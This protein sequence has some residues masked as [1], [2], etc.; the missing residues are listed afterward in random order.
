MTSASTISSSASRGCKGKDAGFVLQALIAQVR[1]L[2][3]KSFIFF[4]SF[5]WLLR[6]RGFVCFSF[7][8]FA[9]Q[10]SNLCIER[11][12]CGEGRRRL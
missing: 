9:G 2:R 10:G 5:L 1:K 7:F 4:P 12:M 8:L 6:F 3:V 11:I